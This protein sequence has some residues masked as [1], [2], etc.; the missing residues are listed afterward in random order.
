LSSFNL[1][2][3]GAQIPN[4]P[5][6]L[7]YNKAP[8]YISTRPYSTLFNG[9]GIHHFDKG[10]QIT[11][12]LFDKGCFL[13]AFDLTA[14]HS[15]I[16][17]CENLLSDGSIRIEGRFSEAL[18]TTITCLVYTEFNAIMEINKDRNVITNF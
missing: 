13:L 18:T 5:I 7:N 1:V 14:D 6:E 17:T 8:N 10:H 15:A 2:V 9:T 16:T 11:K 3:N 12:K 4:Q